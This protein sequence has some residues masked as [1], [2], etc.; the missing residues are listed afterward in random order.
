MKNWYAPP[1]LA[2]TSGA[3]G[4][5]SEL[6]AQPVSEPVDFSDTLDAHAPLTAHSATERI[7]FFDTPEAVAH[8]IIGSKPQEPQTGSIEPI[9]TDLKLF[10]PPTVH[11]TWEHEM[12]SKTDPLPATDVAAIES[13]RSVAAETHHTA[14]SPSPVLQKMRELALTIDDELL[15]CDRQ[16]AELKFKHPIKRN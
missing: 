10:D 4:P 2:R 11:I 7:D 3:R 15:E 12:A 5:L 16:I 14:C 1:P 6:D 13:E 8:R 9:R